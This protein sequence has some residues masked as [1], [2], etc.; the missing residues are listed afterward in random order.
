MR[1]LLAAPLALA[2]LAA[3]LPAAPTTFGQPGGGG[4]ARGTV[5][6]DR[7]ADGTRDAGEPGLAGVGVSNGRDV[8]ET[9]AE[10]RYRIP[11]DRDDA[12]FVIKPRGYRFPVDGLG[13]PR[14]Y[15]IHKPDGSPGGL[16]H[17]GVPPTGP[18]PEAIDFPLT[19]RSEPD[20]FEVLVLGD[21]QVRD[22]TDLSYHARDVVDELVGIEA[23][24]GMMLGDLAYDDLSVYPALNGLM[25]ETGLPWINVHGNHDVNFDVRSDTLS[26]ETWERVYGPTSWSFDWGPVHFVVL[27]DVIYEG[28]PRT[29]SYRGGLA[30]EPLAFLEADLARVDPERLIVIAMHIP[31][32]DFSDGDRAALLERVSRFDR[33]LVLTAHW[34]VQM[35]AFFDRDGQPPVHQLVQATACGSWWLGAPDPFGIPHTTMRDGTPNGY[36]I[37]HFEGNDYRIEF[38]PLGLPRDEQMHVSLPALLDPEE[39]GGREVLINVYAGSPRSIVELRIDGGPWKRA[40]PLTDR[41]SPRYAGIVERERKLDHARRELPDPVPSPHLWR[42]TLPASLD[43]GTHLLEVRTTDMFGQIHSDRR[44]FVVR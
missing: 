14:F 39:A 24:F 35:N 44:T 40:E 9:D 23:A 38:V 29:K 25:A 21:P 30:E 16:D 2:A 19:E 27:D 42:G 41:V 7:D 33:V 5:F 17:A 20:A 13:L 26:D 36:S 28:N 10:G 1:Q 11:V 18:L 4:L 22:E 12:V 31:L 3:L 37:V 6:V 43:P 15:Y 8:V 32:H 34:H